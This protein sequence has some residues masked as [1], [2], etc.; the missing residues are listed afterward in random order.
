VQG[1]PQVSYIAS[2]DELEKRMLTYEQ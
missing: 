1:Y 2:L